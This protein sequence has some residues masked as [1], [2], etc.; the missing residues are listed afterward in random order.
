[1]SEGRA[2]GGPLDH[3]EGA[4]EWGTAAWASEH[5]A[6]GHVATVRGEEGGERLTG[7][8]PCQI[9]RLLQFF[10]FLNFNTACFSYL[11]ELVKQFR[12]IWE[13]SCGLPRS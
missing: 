7:R 1:M 10:P 9:F 3:G 6:S 11:K 8:A 2:G 13:I 5:G 4:S 12:K